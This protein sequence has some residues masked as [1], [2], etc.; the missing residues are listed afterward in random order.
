MDGFITDGPSGIQRQTDTQK[1][2][3]Q[4]HIERDNTFTIKAN[5]KADK[6]IL[7]P[8]CIGATTD[9]EQQTHIQ[10]GCQ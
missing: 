6:N 10:Q 1:T 9:R 5:T 7:R 2:D 3:E 4:T 8:T